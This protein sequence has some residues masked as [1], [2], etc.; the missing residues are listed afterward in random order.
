MTVIHPK[1]NWSFKP[2]KTTTFRLIGEIF[3]SKPTQIPSSGLKSRPGSPNYIMKSD[4]E[5]EAAKEEY[6]NFLFSQM[7]KAAKLGEKFVTA[8][9]PAFR[10]AKWRFK[11]VMKEKKEEERK[12]KGRKRNRKYKLKGDP[13]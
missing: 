12:K 8:D 9:C 2:D 4:A 6:V 3:P 13:E 7:E 5:V 1:Q 10:K 11:R